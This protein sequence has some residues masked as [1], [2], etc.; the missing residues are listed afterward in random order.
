MSDEAPDPVPDPQR[1]PVGRSR[2]PFGALVGITGVLVVGSFFGLPAVLA[3]IVAVT[4]VVVAA[5][6]GLG[7]LGSLPVVALGLV[8]VARA[9]QCPYWGGFSLD[10]LPLDLLFGG[11]C[12]I[13]WVSPDKMP[14]TYEHRDA[15]DAVLLGAACVF[16]VAGLV[17]TARREGADHAHRLSLADA[18]GVASLV[19]WVLWIALFPQ[20]YSNG[21]YPAEIHT[22]TFAAGLAF[23]TSGILM[24]SVLSVLAMQRATIEQRR[25]RRGWFFGGYVLL[26]CGV[27][28]LSF[29]A[30]LAYSISAYMGD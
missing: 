23:A 30:W 16:A 14:W 12:V 29:T 20:G 17:F 15:I 28:Y 6:R 1:R 26:G 9:L 4:C 5:R 10:E 18:V 13:D 21:R 27:G 2:V 24:A 3:Y 8:A 25:S 11:Q 19:G 7:M 22:V